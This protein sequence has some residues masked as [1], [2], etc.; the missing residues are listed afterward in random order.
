[1]KRFFTKRVLIVAAVLL[2]LS[3]AIGTT[4]GYLHAAAEAVE[5]TFTVAGGPKPVIEE[6]FDGTTK[7]NVR[8]R[9][10]GGCAAYVRAAVVFTLQDGDGN[11]LGKV[12]AAG[13]EYS[14]SYGSGWER[15]PDG[16]WYYMGVV[17]DGESTGNLIESC[18]TMCGEYSLVVDIAAQA[19]QAYPEDAVIGAWG[20]V[21]GGLGGGAE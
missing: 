17:N 9:I 19:I 20:F 1:M 13:V 18:T 14:V 12:P 3:A 4:L 21:P 10:D 8:V 15:K 5:N 2:V 7:S 11:I 6:E 16:Y